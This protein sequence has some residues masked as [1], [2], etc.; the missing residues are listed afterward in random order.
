MDRKIKERDVEANTTTK[1]MI[2]LLQQQW[3]PSKGTLEQ[4]RERER[5]REGRTTT[6]PDV[7]ISSSMCGHC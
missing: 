6:S 1:Q 7:W 3:A 2:E 5:E 4:E